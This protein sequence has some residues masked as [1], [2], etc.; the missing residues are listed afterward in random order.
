MARA[1]E[2]AQCQ[3]SSQ[4]RKEAPQ[5]ALQALTPPVRCTSPCCPMAAGMEALLRQR[6]RRGKLAVAARSR[7]CRRS[8]ARV[9][10]E[11]GEGGGAGRAAAEPL[12]WSTR[13]AQKLFIQV[14]A[15]SVPRP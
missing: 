3:L 10:A 9:D 1:W 4:R 12:S 8:R 15:D 14:S 7:R 5:S 13:F 2:T 11:G 6:R